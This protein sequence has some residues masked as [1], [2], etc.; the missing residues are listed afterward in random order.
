[1]SWSIKDQPRPRVRLGGAHADRWSLQ[2]SSGTAHIEFTAVDLFDGS[3]TKVSEDVPFAF[4]A[5]LKVTG[6]E[7]TVTPH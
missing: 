2:D 3:T 5:D 1:M 4:T 7:A 6:D